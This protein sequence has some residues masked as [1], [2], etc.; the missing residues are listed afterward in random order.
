VVCWAQALA[1]SRV[2]LGS[3]NGDRA[4]DRDVSSAPVGLGRPVIGAQRRERGSHQ[5]VVTQ[6]V[7]R[8][9]AQAAELGQDACVVAKM[10]FLVT[11]RGWGPAA[12]GKQ[13]DRGLPVGL[14][15]ANHF[16]PG[17]GTHAVAEEGQ[18]QRRLAEQDVVDEVGEHGHITDGLLGAA[19]LP[20]WVLNCHD[21]DFR[22]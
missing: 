12:R 11:V 6:Q 19:I 22:T 9:S 17:N 15:A 1:S 21:V 2:V 16:E 14:K 18:R 13:P 4:R 20:S 3:Q 8:G 10:D 5:F 7:G